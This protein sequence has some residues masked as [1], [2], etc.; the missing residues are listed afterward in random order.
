MYIGGEIALVSP[1]R[2][3][4]QACGAKLVVEQIA[5]LV[6]I[7]VTK[8]IARASGSVALCRPPK[9]NSRQAQLFLGKRD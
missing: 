4:R 8:S 5:A 9:P 1:V 3:I 6:P 7:N 2:M